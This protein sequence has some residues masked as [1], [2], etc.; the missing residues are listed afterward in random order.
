PSEVLVPADDARAAADAARGVDGV[1]VAVVGTSRGDGAVVDVFPTEATLD[2]DASR[3]V[4]DVR[5]AVDPV[6]SGNAGITGLGPTIEDYFSAVYDK[7]PYVLAAI[8]LITYVLLVRTFRSVLLPLK[9]VVVNL[10]SIGAVFG[11]IVF[12]GQLG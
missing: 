2:S 4:T 12:F 7:L 6:V 11:P 8:A 10:I 1:Q 9:A 3:V 5:S